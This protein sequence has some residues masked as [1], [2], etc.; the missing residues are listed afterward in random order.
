MDEKL[1]RILSELEVG[2]EAAADEMHGTGRR[3]GAAL[4]VGAAV[5]FVKAMMG[6][7]LSDPLSEA[8]AILED[9]INP[10]HKHYWTMAKLIRRIGTIG[11]WNPPFTPDRL[12]LSYDMIEKVLAVTAVDC[13]H[14]AGLDMKSALR[15]VAGDNPTDMK[16]LED[17]RE[18]LP[19][20]DTPQRDYYRLMMMHWELEIKKNPDLAADFSPGDLS[21]V[22][23][24][25]P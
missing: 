11:P 19:R 12:P 17:F 13:L 15:K 9:D 24:P 1:A 8:L 5:R 3:E 10:A 16:K 22:C 21:N 2:L 14:R 25:I 23:P 7:K 6:E 20:R 18:N 4:A